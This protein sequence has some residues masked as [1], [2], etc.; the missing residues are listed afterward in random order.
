MKKNKELIKNYITYSWY[1]ILL[2]CLLSYVLSYYLIDNLLA[3]SL[4]E[5]FSIF[6][7]SNKYINDLNTP[8]KDKYN[9][10]GIELVNIY[11]Y[12]YDDDNISSFYTS[13]G[14]Q[15]DLVILYESDLIDMKE[16]ID[17]KY[18]ILN[19]LSYINEFNNYM[20][21][22]NI[23]GIEVYSNN[24]DSSFLNNYFDFSNEKELKAYIMINKNS[25]HFKDDNDVGYLILNDLIKGD[26]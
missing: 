24:N 18:V 21:N 9:K 13:F 7:T 20:Y 2:I 23:Y 1:I 14:E 17:E 6:V 8:I 5:T 26:L 25:C 16:V 19:S 10:Y 3:Y 4:E 12:K 15:S 22:N 11:N